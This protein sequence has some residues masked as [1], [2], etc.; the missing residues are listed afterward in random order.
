MKR[1][2]T[3]WNETEM[4]PNGCQVNR[5]TTGNKAGRQQQAAKQEQLFHMP[6][7]LSCCNM[8]CHTAPVCVLLRVSVC[9]CVC[10]DAS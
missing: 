8:L 1:N 5:Q 3:K 9:Q 6:L 2:E 10:L 7:H 4:K